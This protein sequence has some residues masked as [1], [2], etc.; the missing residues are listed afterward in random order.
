MLLGSCENGHPQALAKTK[1]ASVGIDVNY[2][3]TIIYVIPVKN[4]SDD[5][6]CGSVL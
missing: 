3:I 5:E 1:G 6:K 4:R 2:C